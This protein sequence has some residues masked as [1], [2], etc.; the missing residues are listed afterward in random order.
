[1]TLNQPAAPA[2]PNPVHD[3]FNISVLV[4]DEITIRMVDASALAD[5]EVW[6]FISSVL[7]SAFVGFLVAHLQ[8]SSANDPTSGPMMWMTVLI[9]L[10][11]GA[12]LIMVFSKR[13]LLKKKGRTMK[14][15]TSLAE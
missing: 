15:K 11:M 13:T 12:S 4:P 2:A 10:L 6:A 14:L 5:Y 3:A 1:M 9:G 8:A 7:S